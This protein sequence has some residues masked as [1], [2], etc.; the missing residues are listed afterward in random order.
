MRLLLVGMLSKKL[1]RL[2]LMMKKLKSRQ[3]P[4]KT[5]LPRPPARSLEILLRSKL[6]INKLKRPKKMSPPNMTHPRSQNSRSKNSR[7]LRKR[8]Y[9]RW[10]QVRF[11]VRFLLRFPARFLVKIYKLNRLKMPG[12]S[13]LV[14]PH[15]KTTL[16]LLPTILLLLPTTL[17]LRTTLV[18]PQTTIRPKG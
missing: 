18:T 12:M 5:M 17:P 3:N 2:K 16:L 15:Q 14:P 8:S 6:R 11:L 1:N 4:W 13:S 7:A 9:L 10:S